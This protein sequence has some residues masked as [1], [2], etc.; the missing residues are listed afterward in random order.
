MAEKIRNI[1]LKT[2]SSNDFKKHGLYDL[3]NFN[4]ILKD[5][6][7][8]D[9]D[10]LLIKG[11][12]GNLFTEAITC[13]FESNEQR[14]AAL[15]KSINSLSAQ[16]DNPMHDKE[17]KSN[18]NEDMESKVFT[19]LSTAIERLP[20]RIIVVGG[21]RPKNWDEFKKSD[22]SHSKKRRC[23]WITR[24]IVWRE[25]LKELA[26][27]QKDKKGP[28]SVYE[29]SN[30]DE[31]T[32]EQLPL[33]IHYNWLDS[34]YNEEMEEG[35]V[36]DVN[37]EKKISGS[38][39]INKTDV[40]ENF[41]LLVARLKKDVLPHE[42]DEVIS[43]RILSLFF[44]GVESIKLNEI[45]KKIIPGKQPEKPKRKIEKCFWDLLQED[46]PSALP[47]C[48]T[49]KEENIE[50]SQMQNEFYFSDIVESNQLLI[51]YSRHD[52][53]EPRFT[54][55]KYLY[56]EELSG[57]SSHFSILYNTLI[58]NNVIKKSG[59]IVDLL[60]NALTKIVIADERIANF[61]AGSKRGRANCV[62]GGV[63]VLKGVKDLFCSPHGGK[64]ISDFTDSNDLQ[65]F[66]DIKADAEKGA[67]DVFII[68]QGILDKTGLSTSII[69]NEL[70]RWKKNYFPIIVVTSGRGT[71]ANIP[72]NAR[73]I[74][75]SILESTMLTVNIS[76][77]PLIKVVY[78]SLSRR[79]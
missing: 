56:Q 48:F 36:I 60:E 16:N 46:K 52:K 1:T 47:F 54:G 10:F 49:T 63:T 55:T 61:I 15:V 31:V 68:H 4:K 65:N 30:L 79:V 39:Q 7:P 38:Y 5:N 2:T 25:S 70:D 24:R 51:K 41:E 28:A 8:L 32:P 35:P 26:I 45:P 19:W 27:F 40:L 77:M 11:E 43:Q 13:I 64:L 34:M 29:I 6:T 78:K 74:P 62:G 44:S 18:S 9:Y 66:S 20:R 72:K 37:L 67:Y 76:K 21:E 73:F 3:D 59:L 58:G 71:P 14:T 33:L 53:V 17:L 22:D 12:T 50:N 23:I 75:F 69:E 57:N 42:N